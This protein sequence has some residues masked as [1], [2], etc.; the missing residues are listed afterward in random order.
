MLA[1]T[2]SVICTAAISSIAF[3]A[4]ADGQT[5]SRV[6]EYSLSDGQ[7]RVV[8]DGLSGPPTPLWSPT[9]TSFSVFNNDPA[10]PEIHIYR[11]SGELRKRIRLPQAQGNGGEWSADE[12]WI[13]YRGPLGAADRRLVVVSTTSDSTMLLAPLEPL[14]HWPMVWSEGSQHILMLRRPP[15]ASAR[16]TTIES[17]DLEGNTRV[18]HRAN[19][20]SGPV[21]DSLFYEKRGNAFF[22]GHFANPAREYKLIPEEAGYLSSP[23]F[24][25]DREWVAFRRNPAGDNNSALTV[26][27]VMRLDGSGRTKITLPFPAA[28]GEDNPQFVPGAQALIVTEDGRGTASPGMYLVSIATG[29]VKRLASVSSEIRVQPQVSV[30]PDGTKVLFWRNDKLK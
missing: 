24:S 20:T 28:P 22:V 6:Y 3:A 13:L 30:S 2:R 23:A 17:V 25:R 4:R 14:G 18:L 11:S 19:D 5:I 26:L 8:V 21:N 7:S 1:S 15:S 12:R 9:G 10:R 27:E 29:E 16:S